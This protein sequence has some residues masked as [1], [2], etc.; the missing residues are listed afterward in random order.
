M[1]RIAILNDIHSCYLILEQILKDL[2]KDDIDEYFIGGDSIT[3]GFQDNEVL[4]TLKNLPS[5]FINGNRELSVLN[6]YEKIK[7]FYQWGNTIYSCEHLNKENKE[8]ISKLPIYKIITIENQKIC[9]SHG[10][11]YNVRDLVAKNDYD[12]FD[13]LIDDFNCDIYLFAHTHHAFYTKYKGKLFIN[14]GSISSPTD[15]PRSS[16]GL[17]TINQDK[18]N[19]EQRYYYYNFEDLKKYY[20]NT[21]YYQKCIE[22]CNLLLYNFKTG[23]DNCIPFIKSIKG[24]NNTEE[25]IPKKVYYDYFVKF[26]QENNLEIL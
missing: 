9:I 13:K 23:K 10:S 6:D 14:S 3:D 11:P 12:M 4:N 7:N 20:L 17:L 24:Y 5:T 15:G 19:Y 26:M 18:I 16:Y 2:K 22:W 8:F 1:K 21:E 25:N